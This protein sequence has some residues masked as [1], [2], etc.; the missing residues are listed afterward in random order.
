MNDKSKV[1]AF[2]QEIADREFSNWT[3]KKAFSCVKGL[4]STHALTR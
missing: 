2:M 3:A 4:L 1:K